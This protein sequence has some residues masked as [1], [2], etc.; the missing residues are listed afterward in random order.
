M[1]YDIIL[2]GDIILKFI[3]IL[4]SNQIAREL[5][6]ALVTTINDMYYL[7]D[8]IQ[9]SNKLLQEKD[10]E[11]HKTSETKEVSQNVVKYRI[12]E[13]EVWSG[14]DS[15]AKTEITIHHYRQIEIDLDI[16]TSTMKTF[17]E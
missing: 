11:E 7:P 12:I 13:P 1:I 6:P 4:I 14:E 16:E 10:K 15:L 9:E 3:L 2:K 8:D 5:R 17:I